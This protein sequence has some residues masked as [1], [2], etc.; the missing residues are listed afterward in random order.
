MNTATEGIM[1]TKEKIAKLKEQIRRKAATAGI[2]L[3]ASAT[4]AS[5][6]PKQ[7]QQSEENT[8]KQEQ[9]STQG[10][11]KHDEATASFEDARWREADWAQ[12]VE[13]YK[14]MIADGADLD[15]RNSRQY[16]KSVLFEAVEWDNIKGAE[17]LLKAGANPNLSMEGE[18]GET[19]V[20]YA[21]SLEMVKL[22]E[23]YGA[24]L[25][26]K[27]KM[28]K[29]PLF[30]VCLTEG[31]DGKRWNEDIA[32]YLIE[33][34]NSISNLDHT[35]ISHC[36]P[37]QFKF[38]QD[39]GVKLDIQKMLEATVGGNP[40]VLRL[41]LANGGKKY[42]NSIYPD[43]SMTPLLDATV[44]AAHESGDELEKSHEI[45]RLL[46]DNGAD[47]HKKSG[48]STPLEIAHEMQ[49][50]KLAEFLQKCAAERTAKTQA[51][52]AVRGR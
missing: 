46:I 9:L 49:D 6:S 40:E 5:C 21:T 10:E 4:M 19:P 41:V 18:Q 35:Y 11:Q 37:E 25:N 51:M 47:I 7:A 43:G 8:D 38:Y 52:Q 13:E 29:Q 23:K 12:Q 31:S 39:K 1:K 27:N 14:Q 32:T 2:I 26:Y 20:F 17:L 22:L 33:K 44:G 42:V 3:A 36:T 15:K 48:S 50:E 16:G 45:I 24:D 28:G 34:G 30:A